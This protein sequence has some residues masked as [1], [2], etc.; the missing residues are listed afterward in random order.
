MLNKYKFYLTTVLLILVISCD[1]KKE[2]YNVYFEKFIDSYNSLQY[3]NI[4]SKY[5]K[6]EIPKT[7]EY[8]NGMIE[9]IDSKEL[10]FFDLLKFRILI[11]EGKYEEA[12][13]KL[14]SIKEINPMMYYF[15]KA[16]VFE[17]MQENNKAELNYKKSL[18][19]CEI[20]DFCDFISFFSNNDFDS[21]LDKVKQYNNMGYQHYLKIKSKSKNNKDIRR[22]LLIDEI[23]HNYIIPDNK[24][25]YSD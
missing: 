13:N 14:S 4:N 7:Y 11:I 5:N 15:Y 2:K 6:L 1:K 24:G 25:H 17:I 12:I 9:N 16:G 23:F 19:F 10:F 18:T 22:I 21:F 3:D 20:K 8:I